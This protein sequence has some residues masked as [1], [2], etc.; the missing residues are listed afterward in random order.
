[1]LF[2]NQIQPLD[3]KEIAE[4]V[5]AHIGKHENF[6]ENNNFRCASRAAITL[7]SYPSFPPSLFLSPS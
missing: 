1:M 6:Y 7:D 2:G 3:V 5:Y 4:G